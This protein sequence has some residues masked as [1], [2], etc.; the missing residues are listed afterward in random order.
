M[1]LPCSQIPSNFHILR[2]SNTSSRNLLLHS[3]AN[4]SLIPSEAQV[5]QTFPLHRFAYLEPARILVQALRPSGTIREMSP[6]QYVRSRTDRRAATVCLTVLFL[7]KVQPARRNPGHGVTRPRRWRCP[8]VWRPVIP[9]TSGRLAYISFGRFLVVLKVK[10]S[11]VSCTYG[12]PRCA[13]NVFL[14]EMAVYMVC[15]WHS[16]LR[17][18]GG[19]YASRWRFDGLALNDLTSALEVLTYDP[20]LNKCMLFPYKLQ[21]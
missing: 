7:G 13:I 4:P 5:Q 15:R 19:W 11:R 16:L 10:S 18:A 8:Q 20:E 1:P 2:A 14:G 21:T 17:D 3:G 6:A 12:K 9:D